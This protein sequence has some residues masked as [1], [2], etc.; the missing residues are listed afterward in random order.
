ML[1][2]INQ[3]I[4]QLKQKQEKLHLQLENN[5]L[6]IN[7]V[8]N[9]QTKRSKNYRASVISGFASV[10]GL[11]LTTVAIP[12]SLLLGIFS[13]PCTG[14]FVYK[15]MQTV[16]M[17]KPHLQKMVDIL[18]SKNVKRDI[19]SNDLDEKVAEVLL[20]EKSQ[21]QAE[22][23]QTE[24]QINDLIK[25]RE[26]VE[27]EQNKNLSLQLMKQKQTELDN[28]IAKSL[29]RNQYNALFAKYKQ[30]N[31][32]SETRNENNSLLKNKNSNQISDIT[33]N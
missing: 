16:D 33:K 32:K 5:K 13:V 11:I 30:Q 26:D 22:L 24:M 27:R 23:T 29:T 6:T 10:I 28:K 8:E 17:E 4:E 7:L 12:T 31:Q 19:Y 25:Q 14:Y 3:Q 20:N 15:T 2:Q 9:M 1:K 21:L 18:K